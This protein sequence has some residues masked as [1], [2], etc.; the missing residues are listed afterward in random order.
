MTTEHLFRLAQQVSNGFKER[1]CTLALFLDVRAAFD[2]VWRNGLKFKIDKIGLTKQMRN[3]LFSF[4]DERTLRVNVDGTWSDVVSLEAG[5]PQGSCLSPLLY[6]IFVND[7][8]E[9]LNPEKTTASQYADDLG[10]WTTQ[11]D[12]KSA[13]EVIQ[14]AV[15]ALEQWCRK[16][17]VSMHPSKS[18]LIL[19]TKCFRHKAEV[20]QNGLSV[21]LF[22]EKV[23]AVDEAVFLG[24]TFDSRLTYEPQIK[25]MVEK[26]YKRLNLLRMI[27]SMSTEHK[28]DMLATLYNSIIRPVFEYSSICTVTTAE[29][30]ME[31]LQLLQNQA[32]RSI[33]KTPNYVSVKDLHDLSGISLIKGHLI[34]FARKQ[35]ENMK[36]HSPLIQPMIDSYNKVAH[37]KENASILDMLK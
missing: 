16:W 26:A 29:C 3:L 23:E 30:H 35:L 2:S 25:R 36:S 20:E 7:V 12:V 24:V 1:K 14:E 34:S 15:T 5:T 22:N 9:V 8:T 31:K 27:A 10:I 18:K 13:T 6:L 17:Y 4:L 19:F 28:P 37:I 33:L 21:M 11:S 32:L